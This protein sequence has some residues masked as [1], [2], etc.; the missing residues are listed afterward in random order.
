MVKSKE[1]DHHTCDRIFK[2]ASD[3]FEEK[4]FAAAR[5]QEIANRA[6]INKAL[7]HYY[8]RSKDHLFKAVFQVLLK[9]MFEKIISI[10]TEDI[11]F[12]EKIRKFFN[13]H[14]DFLM[15]N[16]DLPI[17]LLNEISRNP[18]LAEGLK[19]MLPYEQLR[20][21]I[22]TR[23]AKE[24]KG[25]G[26]KEADMPQLM[27]TVVSLSVFPFAARDMLKMLMPQM[28]DNKKF[29]S[30]MNK[31]KEFAADFVIT[32]LKNRKK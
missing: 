23:H 25:Y 14:I 5:M 10:F 2:A 27:I 3:V 13:Q 24:L 1:T 17:F 12:K 11:S 9:K 29:N 6:G 30:Y 15:K 32:A 20:D 21:M 31:R 4:G 18:S 26:I 16:P 8:F 28:G 7:L 19:E 22:Y